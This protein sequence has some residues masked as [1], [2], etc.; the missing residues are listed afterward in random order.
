MTHRIGKPRN[1]MSVRPGTRCSHA[2]YLSVSSYKLR[3]PPHWYKFQAI[4]APFSCSTLKPTEERKLYLPSSSRKMSQC[5][6]LLAKPGSYVHLRKWMLIVIP[7]WITWD[8][9][10]QAGALQ[11]RIGKLSL[12]EGERILGRQNQEMLTIPLVMKKKKAL[13]L[14][15]CYIPRHWHRLGSENTCR[16]KSYLFAWQRT[17]R[18]FACFKR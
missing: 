3:C 12:E 11:W 8:D 9:S 14:Q 4:V 1:F 15:Q 7:I 2:G 5:W 6:C 13:G 17:L 16:N 18:Q 10:G